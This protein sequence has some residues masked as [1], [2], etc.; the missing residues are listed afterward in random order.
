MADVQVAVGLGREPG[1]DPVVAALG[2][3][4]VDDLADEIGE[5]GAVGHERIPFSRRSSLGSQD[6]EAA[7]FMACK[8]SQSRR[9]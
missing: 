5:V 6:P 3:I 8:G 7:S 9:S 2:Q 1:V 4:R